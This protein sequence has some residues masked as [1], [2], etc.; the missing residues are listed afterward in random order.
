MSICTNWFGFF[1]ANLFYFLF[2]ILHS[3]MFRPCLFIILYIV[4]VLSHIS[5]N[6]LTWIWSFYIQIFWLCINPVFVV[7][8]LLLLFLVVYCCWFSTSI[9]HTIYSILY[10]PVLPLVVRFFGYL[11]STTDISYS[12]FNCVCE[13]RNTIPVLSLNHLLHF[14][15]KYFWLPIMTVL[16]YIMTH[17]VDILHRNS[18]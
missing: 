6:L 2:L 5:S 7:L 11:I 14:L 12:I 3:K 8:F 10:V 1:I 18:I 15:Q 4:L 13:Q 9:L 16:L 17:N